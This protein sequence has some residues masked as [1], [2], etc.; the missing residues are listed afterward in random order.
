MGEKATKVH[1]HK[2]SVGDRKLPE[3]ININEANITEKQKYQL[4]TFSSGWK[5]IFQRMQKILENMT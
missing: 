4:T 5:D 3:G 1:Q 2:I